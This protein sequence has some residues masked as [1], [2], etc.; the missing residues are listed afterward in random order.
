MHYSKT[1]AQILLGLPL[2][3][4]ENAIEYRKLKKI[5]NQVVR[6]LSSL[7]LSP[8]VLHGLLESESLQ[9]E[10]S[11]KEEN[12]TISIQAPNK[13]EPS[14]HLPARIIYELNENSNR[15]EPRLRLLTV[16]TTS[17]L[18]TPCPTT[19]CSTGQTA[20]VA[21]NP[22]VE[23]LN[24]TERSI[25]CW[26][27]H[28]PFADGDKSSENSDVGQLVPSPECHSLANEVVIPLQADAAFFQLLSSTL[29]S[30]AVHLAALHED[31]VRNLQDLSQTIGNMAKPSSSLSL[32]TFRPYS[33]FSSHAGLIR[34]PSIRPKKTDLYLW[35][36]VFQLYIECEIFHSLHEKDRG[37]RSS[38]ESHRRLQ[39]FVG[40]LA[41]QGLS[42]SQQ[43]RSK[44]NQNALN[45]FLEL[46][47]FVLNIKKF[48]DANIEATRKILKKHT[49]RT[50]LKLPI[51]VTLSQ[52]SESGSLHLPRMLVQ[53]IGEILLPI[54]PHVDDYACAI[55]TG[56]AFK[57]IRLCCGHLFCV[58]CL[59]K[60]Q[61]RLQANC[62]ICRS[63]TVLKADKSN[64]D[65]ALVNFMQDWF[66]VEAREKLLSNEQEAIEEELKELGFDLD[67]SCLV[68]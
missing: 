51:P 55:C 47:L 34:A 19:I 7:G 45:V 65:W 8:S 49:K 26:P 14:L 37:E 64:V 44:Q 56:I 38:E 60:M 18:N 22:N 39:L 6:E 42:D 41:S 31:F 62:P 57:P 1:Y 30:V 43:L 67:R 9:N 16:H 20:N 66:P 11:G 27:F 36:K 33:S 61:K 12:V 46:N 58:R 15:F 5:I 2:E 17:I 23:Y 35:R 25:S 29:K 10:S 48:Q 21:E 4:R 63:S 3:L 32:H 40:R 24:I 59:V 28:G 50:A 68:M 52:I 54:I 53:A 13:T